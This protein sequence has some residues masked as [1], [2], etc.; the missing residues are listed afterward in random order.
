MQGRWATAWAG[1]PRSTTFTG[2]LGIQVHGRYCSRG[3]WGDLGRAQK[4]VSLPQEHSVDL[5][6]THF[7]ITMVIHLTKVPLAACSPLSSQA[8]VSTAGEQSPCSPR[9]HL[10]SPLREM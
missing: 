2:R 5:R 1:S 4:S 8:L 3:R 7:I 9:V 6:G 10:A